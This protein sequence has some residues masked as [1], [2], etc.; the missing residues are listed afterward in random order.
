MSQR[1]RIVTINTGKG[2]GD[3]AARL[4]VLA[5]GLVALE[6]D[7]VVAQE[8][9]EATDGSRSTRRRLAEALGMS[10]AFH[11][12]RRKPRLV[13]GGTVDS[14]SGLATLS[15]WPVVEVTARALPDDPDDGDRAALLVAVEGPRG[16]VRIA[17]THLTHLRH[18]D[19]LRVAQ[20]VEVLAD[21][22]WHGDAA[23]RVLAGDLNARAGHTVH[24][25]L[26]SGA[27]GWHALDAFEAAGDPARSATIRHLAGDEV[28]EARLDYV[29]L[30][31]A[32]GERAALTPSVARV[33]LDTPVDGL[34]PSDHFGVLVDLV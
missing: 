26:R 25:M 19:D 31:A 6:P 21:P 11:A 20:A 22:W 9:L 33:V 34:L 10:V 13:D 4:E 1:L 18:R 7:I 24:T 32:T 14:W 23:A 16:L 27:A 30:L 12:V 29:Y 28:V 15:R 8:V 17:N 3:Y 2:D 5:D